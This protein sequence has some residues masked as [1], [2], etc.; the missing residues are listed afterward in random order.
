[1]MRDDVVKL[2]GDAGTLLHH[3]PS[4]SALGHRLLRR[5]ECRDRQPAF[6]QRLADDERGK[7]E[8]QRESHS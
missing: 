3:R 5:V 7:E 1:M 8:E 2:A 4:A 6:A